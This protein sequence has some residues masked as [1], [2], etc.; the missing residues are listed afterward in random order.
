[1]KKLDFNL[2]LKVNDKRLYPT[3]SVKYVDVKTDSSLSWIDH[4][5]YTAIKL[6]RA[7][8]LLSKV[9]KCVNIT[10]LK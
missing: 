5:N 3:K 10:I 4:I 8:G 2:K 9:R 6:N 1:M 7:K